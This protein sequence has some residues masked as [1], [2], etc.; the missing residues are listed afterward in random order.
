MLPRLNLNSLQI[1]PRRESPLA[2]TSGSG[3]LATEKKELR[4]RVLYLG[5]TSPNS[6]VIWTKASPTL[7]LICVPASSASSP[8]FV[9]IFLPP[10]LLLLFDT[11]RFGLQLSF[12]LIQ[13]LVFLILL[14]C[15]DLFTFGFELLGLFL[16]FFGIFLQ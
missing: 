9:C 12:L 14:L 11:F 7:V 1:S 15:F 6:L 2:L 10:L 16:N 8:S 3:S 13:Y 4:S 5:A